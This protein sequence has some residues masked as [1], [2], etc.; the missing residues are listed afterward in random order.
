MEATEVA[1]RDSC[2]CPPRAAGLAGLADEWSAPPRRRSWQELQAEAGATKANPAPRRAADQP[3]TRGPDRRL[4]G[5][6]PFRVPDMRGWT[7]KTG[8][9][10]LAEM[11]EM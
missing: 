2:G 6:V 8:T 7:T 9:D 11:V 1:A 5:H 10:F 3:P 4:C